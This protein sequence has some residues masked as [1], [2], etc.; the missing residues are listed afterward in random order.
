[1]FVGTEEMRLHAL[2]AKSGALLWTSSQVYGRS[3]HD[4]SPVYAEGQVIVQTMPDIYA[5]STNDLDLMRQAN[6]EFSTT[7]ELAGAQQATLQWL[8]Q[9]PKSQTIYVMDA[10]TGEQSFTPGVLYTVVNSGAQ[11]PPVYAKGNLYTAFHVT[12]P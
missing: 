4:Y 12:A 10:V 3:F 6:V 8:A 1:V 7:G 9:N 11:P 2:N 5:Y